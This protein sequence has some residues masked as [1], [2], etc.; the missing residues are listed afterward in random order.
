MILEGWRKD[1]RKSK[2]KILIFLLKI[3]SL[4]SLFK[5]HMQISIKHQNDILIIYFII[6]EM[7][8]SINNINTAIHR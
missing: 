2:I 3:R 7:F 5:L 4:I 1:R 6:P 8:L